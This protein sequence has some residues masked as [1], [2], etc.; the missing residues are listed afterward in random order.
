MVAAGIAAVVSLLALTRLWGLAVSVR[1]LTERRGNDRLASLVER[2]S[3]VVVLV[4][5]DGRIS[6]TSPALQAV[7]GYNEGEWVGMQVE[8][9]DIRAAG[10]LWADVNRL[11]PE[12]SLTI[13]VSALHA[14][15]ERRTMELSAVN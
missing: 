2:S 9:L 7:L 13:E 14:D 6:Y 5:A 1:N 3:D 15:G 10:E 4:D 8:D 12:D 11:A